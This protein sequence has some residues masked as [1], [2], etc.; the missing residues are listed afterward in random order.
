[1]IIVPCD[2]VSPPLR[3]RD[4]RPSRTK[5]RERQN[6]QACQAS[7]VECASNEV[8]VVPEDA[9]AVVPKVILREEADNCPTEQNARLRLVVW[10]VACVLNELGKVDLVEGE[11]ADLRNEL[12]GCQ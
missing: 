9:R 1:M 2:I 11:F 10:N 6:E 12:F 3:K 7:S 8:R 5:H 4:S